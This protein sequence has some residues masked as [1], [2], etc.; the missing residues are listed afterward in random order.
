MKLIE[1]TA[2]LLAQEPGVEGIYEQIELCGRTC[3]KSEDKIAEGTA[4]PFVDKMIA[5]HHTAMLEHGT[6]YLKVPIN[7][8][9]A[10]YYLDDIAT[11]TKC[12]LVQEENPKDNWWAITTNY[13]VLIERKW[14]DDLKYVCA[15]TEHHEKRYSFKLITSIGVTR[16][17]NRHRVH[18]IAEQ[19]T[20]YCNYTK[21]KF[22]NELTF[23]RPSWFDRQV[24]ITIYGKYIPADA[25]GDFTQEEARFTESL[26]NAEESYIYLIKC[27]WQPQQARE[28]LP[29]CTATE[30]CP[31]AFASDWRHF[32]RLRYKEETGKVHPNMKQIATLIYNEFKK[33]GIEEV[34][35]LDE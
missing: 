27:G 35:N 30:I 4:K 26:S 17:L 1:P 9:V 16:E 23:I 20:R 6:V 10:G 19:S 22:G 2:T 29:L 18:S 14:L 34:Y 25:K 13:R 21:D 28:V 24:A 32:L 3:Y 31:T 33:N 15:P 12:H 7:I 8:D 5:S 11:W